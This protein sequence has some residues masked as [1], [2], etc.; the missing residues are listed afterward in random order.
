MLR[1][2]A[3]YAEY[4]RIQDSFRVY[5]RYER[6]HVSVSLSVPL[7]EA[8]WNDH[9]SLQQHLQDCVKYSTEVF[10][11][12]CSA[13]TAKSSKESYDAADELS[14]NLKSVNSRRRYSTGQAGK[15]WRIPYKTKSMCT[16]CSYLPGG[17]GVARFGQGLDAVSKAII[18]E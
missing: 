8:P 2:F 17:Q 10:C 4:V 11:L 7:N 15:H 6:S 14:L 1:A 9:R 13:W 16:R 3:Y 12:G 5:L 18:K